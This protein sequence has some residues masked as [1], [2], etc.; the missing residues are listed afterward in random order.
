MKTVFNIITGEKTE[1]PLSAEELAAQAEYLE[2]EPE[3]ARKFAEESARADRDSRLAVTDFHALSD[4]AMSEAMTTYRQALRDVP[5]Q[6]G[7][8]NEIDWPTEPV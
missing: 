1:V 3:R 5:Q 7:F 2:G 4:T 6:G 8:P